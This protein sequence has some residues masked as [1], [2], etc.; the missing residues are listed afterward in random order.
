[1]LPITANRRRCTVPPALCELYMPFNKSMLV[2]VPVPFEFTRE[3][4]VRRPPELRRVALVVA[5]AV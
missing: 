2:V 1:M 4:Y 3:N 5:P